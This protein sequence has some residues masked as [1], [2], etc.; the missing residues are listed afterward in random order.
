MLDV[1]IRR[2]LLMTWL[3]LAAGL[4]R[5]ATA[6]PVPVGEGSVT[7]VRLANGSTLLVRE[8]PS[9]PVVAL[10][11][12]VR[13]GSVDE[14]ADE[15]GMAHL[16]EHMIFKGTRKRGVG[17]ISRAVEAAGGY[18]NAFTSY[19]H[20]CFYVVLPSSRIL[21]ALDVQ[22]DAFLNSS[23]DAKELAKEKEV[24]FEEMRM[25]QDD[26][27]AWSW[28]ILTRAVFTKSPYHWPI[29]GE[30][31]LL[32][33]VDRSRL[34][35]YYRTRYVPRNSVISVVGDVKA[36]EVIQW[37]RKHFG[38]VKGP[39]PPARRFQDDPE[40]RALR[41]R[42]EPGDV[43]QVYASIGF[44]A[45]PWDHPDAAPLEILDSILGEGGASRLGVAL[46]EKNRSADEVSAA[47]FFGGHG[48]AFVIQGLTD[49]ARLDT[50]GR[51]VFA[52]IGRIAANGVPAR[53][54]DKV[55]TNLKASK[56]FEKQSVDGQ[57]KTLGY[58][59]LQGDY[60]RED[61][62]LAALDAVTSDDLRRVAARYLVPRRATLVL[63]HPRGEA[64]EASPSRWQALFQSGLDSTAP[65]ADPDRRA[66][67]LRH[68]ALSNGSDL[69]VKERHGVPL[70]SIG[71][72]FKGGFPE[73]G[74]DRAGL[75]SLM[76]RCLMKGTSRRDFVRFA[77]SLESLAAHL[78]PVLE[79]DYWGLTLDCLSSRIDESFALMAEAL[80]EPLFDAGEVDKEKTLQLAAIRRLKDDPA[81]YGFLRSALLTFAGTS[82]AHE[83]M[84]NE[85]T[86]AS[87]GAPDV[88]RWF[89]RGAT[90][91]NLTWVVVG[92]VDP[93]AFRV[94][95]EETFRGMPP[96]SARDRRSARE[97]RPVS[98]VHEETLD[99]KQATVILGFPAPR[100]EDRD[101]F[102][103]KVLNAALNGMGARLFTE[104][105][106]KRSLAYSVFA[107]HEA[108]SEAGVYRAYIGCA[109]EKVAEARKGLL[110][111]LRSVAEAPLSVEELSRSKS[112]IT[113]LYQVGL[114]S[115]RA[116]M[117]SYARYQVSGPGAP[118]VDEYPGKIAAVSAKDV[119]EAARRCFLQ[120]EPTWVILRP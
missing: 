98:A 13:A 102:T 44:P 64:P 83:P 78:E 67:G 112:Y 50:Y 34:L 81:E 21:E 105:R 9:T 62:Y 53:E 32:R 72:F 29:I 56:L 25:R 74:N 45:V 57:A 88:R 84:G 8:D 66:P 108:L 71:A 63:Y 54:L 1:Q 119:Q 77:E 106:D 59:E 68:I 30:R 115:N 16:I 7:R 23:F 18:L 12:W 52:E 38:V 94:L 15:R 93:E 101:Y 6:Q 87:F 36:S 28:E 117:M 110:E 109:P 113:G 55:K 40:P 19:E 27:W 96:G 26:P 103:F 76:T 24:V 60:R 91:R 33:K 31:D 2:F 3:P 95:V 99:R 47:H 89:E 80:R 17:E 82:Y 5:P 111:V 97:H 100:F 69:W 85:R 48:G 61:A 37:V 58:W 75:T 118:L 11:I 46:R 92:D 70:V 116:Q 43:K 107:A 65:S 10:N 41:V 79:E 104:L 39:A 4:S 49:A 86:L 73:E 22:F 20:T 114:Q 51:E 35:S 14:R 120:G 90:S 42:L